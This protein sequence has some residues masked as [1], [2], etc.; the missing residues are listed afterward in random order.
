ETS[1]DAR[2]IIDLLM[3]AA[4][5]GSEVEI[6]VEGNDEEMVMDEIERVLIDGAGF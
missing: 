3:L 6:V 4:G 1:A 2:S 5:E